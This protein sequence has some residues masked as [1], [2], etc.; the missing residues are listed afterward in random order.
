[1]EN[2]HELLLQRHSIRKYTDEALDPEQVKLILEAALL[3]PTSKNGRPWNFV[4]VDDRETL[5]KMSACKP[6]YATSIA[7]A[8]MAVVVTVD[9]E[10]SEAYLEDAAIAAI[11]MALQAE[12]LGLGACWVQVRGREDAEGEPSENVIRDILGIPNSQLV[13]CV[14]TFGH[15]AEQRRPVDPAKLKWEKVHVGRWRREE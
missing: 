12:D 3:A 1:M 8:A 4:V 13:E 11:F 14:M 15:K 5:K 9:P 7:D 2:I 10:K 6:V